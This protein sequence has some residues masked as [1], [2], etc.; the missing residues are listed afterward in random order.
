M[1]LFPEDYV[2]F[3]FPFCMESTI[4][5]SLPDGGFLPC[6]HGLDLDISLRENSFT[7]FSSFF[8]LSSHL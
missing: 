4:R 7:F 2:L 1:S 8:F 3:P 6:D 5:F